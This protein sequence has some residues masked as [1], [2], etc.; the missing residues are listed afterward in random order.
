MS[1]HQYGMMYVLL[2]YIIYLYNGKRACAYAVYA[3][4]F[5]YKT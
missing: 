3:V 5:R 4:T 2:F 1:E